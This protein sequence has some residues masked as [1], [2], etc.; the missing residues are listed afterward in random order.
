MNKLF[1]FLTIVIGC[2]ALA[3]TANA[4]EV[5]QDQ[6][7][8]NRPFDPSAPNS[9]YYYAF[10]DY[11]STTIVNTLSQGSLDQSVVPYTNTVPFGPTGV[12]DHVKVLQY[13]KK[14]FTTGIKQ[15]TLKFNIRMGCTNYNASNHPFP[16]GYVTNAEDDIRL[17]SCA[18]N[19]VDLGTMI[20]ADF[21]LSN[22]GLYAFYERLPFLRT[23]SNYYHSFSQAKRVADRNID[24]V[25][26][27]SIVYDSKQRT[28][29]WYVGTERVLY[30][31]LIGYPSSDPDIVTMLDGGGTD[32]V[33]QPT[34]FSAGFGA[35]TI[36]DGLDYW[37]PSADTG[38]VQLN[39]APAITYVTPSS[40]YDTLSLPSNRLWGQGSVVHVESILVESF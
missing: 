25:H 7:N 9:P 22:Q 32:T 26:D 17:A 13:A 18:M 28:M 39:S 11:T 3:S 30:V 10:F 14:T 24:D 6:F 36:L 1:S 15:N 38:L 20:V 40:F 16:S 31:T 5:F 12:L 8:S 4:L 2:I 29:S 23:P 33:V 27:L 34:G 35:F 21:F 37:N 19:T